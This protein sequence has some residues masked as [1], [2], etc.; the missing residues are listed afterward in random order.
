M[1]LLD[2]GVLTIS[3]PLI[4]IHAKLDEITHGLLEGMLVVNLYQERQLRV[5]PIRR[6]LKPNVEEIFLAAH[7]DKQLLDLIADELFL[8]LYAEEVVL[9][10]ISMLHN[11]YFEARV[12]TE[13]TLHE[14]VNVVH[15]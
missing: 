6:H 3:S 1:E 14:I 7:L 5:F 11:S 13:L 2:S 9:T 12:F 4:Q 15:V 8:G 10:F